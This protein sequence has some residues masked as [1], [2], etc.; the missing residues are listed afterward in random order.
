MPRAHCE[1]PVGPSASEAAACRHSQPRAD[2]RPRAG[3]MAVEDS[4]IVAEG[5]LPSNPATQRPGHVSSQSIWPQASS[6]S[7]S[8]G[9]AHSDQQLGH[10]NQLLAWEPPGHPRPLSVS[11][12]NQGADRPES[13]N[14]ALNGPLR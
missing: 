3:R 12:A 1:K 7:A 11:Y 14:E 13:A 6:G 10:S 9:R 8:V 4:A 2:R 5:G